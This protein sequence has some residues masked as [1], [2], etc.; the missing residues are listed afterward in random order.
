MPRQKEIGKELIVVAERNVLPSLKALGIRPKEFYTD[1]DLFCKKSVYFHDSIVVVL[2]TG[3]HGFSKKRV[4]DQLDE[5]KPNLTQSNIKVVVMSDTILSGCSEYYYYEGLPVEFVRMIKK[6]TANKNGTVVD[7]W[8]TL[9]YTPS[10][11]TKVFLKD[12]N[13]DEL[14]KSVPSQE[15]DALRHRIQIPT[16]ESILQIQKQV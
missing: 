1:F 5:M 15:D 14:L 10:E 7:I 9:G 16:M 8:G 12:S 3:T 13:A 6:K 4:I 2:F 11:K